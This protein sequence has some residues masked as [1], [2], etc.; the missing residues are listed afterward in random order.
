MKNEFIESVQR[1]MLSFLTN[2]QQNYLKK[3]LE[4]AFCEFDLEKEIQFEDYKVKKIA[5]TD[6]FL[7][8]KRIEGCSDKSLIYYK[9]TIEH[10]LKETGKRPEQITTEDIRIYLMNY[11]N[12]RNS[13]KVTIDNIRRILSSFFSWLEDEDYIIKR[14]VRRIHKVK[15]GK[16]IKETY[17]DEEMERMRDSC[18]SKRNLAIIDMLSST[19]MRIGEMTK[20]K[21]S[22]VNFSERE[23]LVTGKGNK[24]RIVY[25]DARTKI[26]LIN[27]IASRNDNSQY[28]FVSEKAPYKAISSGG[29]E[30]MLRKL[31]KKLSIEK[32]HPHKFRR[33]LATSAID[34]G[35]PIEQVQQLLGHQKIDTT[36]QYAMVKQQNVKQSH[37]RYCS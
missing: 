9:R 8:A 31:G 21:K 25:F 13:S 5:L 6:L 10:L 1:K 29:I 7:D 3:A 26:H 33:T 11:Q 28:L 35:M 32:V 4:E 24:E 23:C 37:R 19:G 22:D 27:Y 2:E 15:T 34:K 14:P 36:L 17:K 30:S 16:V 18:G 20:L 12:E